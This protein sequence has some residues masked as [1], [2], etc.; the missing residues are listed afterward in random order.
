MSPSRQGTSTA[1]LVKV[2]GLDGVVTAVGAVAN[3]ARVGK[4]RPA[5]V[6]EPLV[7]SIKAA[8]SPAT[9][10]GVPG[11]SRD[12]VTTVHGLRGTQ[13][14]RDQAQYARLGYEDGD[15]YG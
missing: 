1:G 2:T 11:E 10:H 5:Q 7:V 6:T 4:R 9:L 13:R 8:A 15:S 12:V 3:T 14:L